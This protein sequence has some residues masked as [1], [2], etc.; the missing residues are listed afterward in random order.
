M[1]LGP[2]FE[3]LSATNEVIASGV[4]ASQGYG[5][6][7]GFLFA[8]HART[9]QFYIRNNGA[10]PVSVLGVSTSGIGGTAFL[11]SEMPATVE[12]GALAPFWVMFSPPTAEVYACTIEIANDST[13]IP[14]TLNFAGTGIEDRRDIEI[15][16]GNVHFNINAESPFVSYGNA[17]LGVDLILGALMEGGT[18]EIITGDTLGPGGAIVMGRDL[19]YDGIGNSGG[20]LMLDADGD[21]AINGAIKTTDS[22]ANV[23]NLNLLS[24]EGSVTQAA[25]IQVRDLMLAVGTGEVVLA[26][27]SNEFASV[28]GTA[29]GNIQIVD[30]VGAIILGAGGLV[31]SGNVEVVTAGAL[32]MSGALQ[33]GGD[34]FLDAQSGSIAGAGTVSANQLAALA[35]NGG[36]SLNIDVEEVAFVAG[37]DVAIINVGE[38]LVAGQTIANNGSIDVQTAAGNMAVGSVIGPIPQAG[39]IADGG[40]NVTLVAGGAGSDVAVDAAV[41]ST[42]G[43]IEITAANGVATT[44]KIGTD[45]RVDVLAQGGDISIGGAIDPSAVTLTA[46][47]DVDVDAAVAADDSI[48]V[49]AGTDGAGSVNVNAGGSLETLAAGSDIE[50]T[51]G[52]TAGN[53]NLAGDVTAVDAV[54]LA[55]DAVNGQISQTAGSLTANNLSFSAGESVSLGSLA[56]STVTGATVGGNIG[57]VNAG[58][59]EILG[60]DSGGGDIDVTS[61]LSL[62]VS[63]LV[64]SGNGDI[65]LAGT[66][67]ALDNA[68][69]AGL[70][71]VFLTANA[72]NIAGAGLVTADALSFSSGD[73]VSLG[74]LAVA[75]ATGASVGGN[76]ELVNAGA[77]AILGLDSGG[78]DI[79]V[80]S[81][82]SLTVGGMVSSGGG[83]ITLEGS[84]V[85]LNSAVNAGLG[86]VSLVA[87]TGGIAGAGLVTA[88]GLSFSSGD[89]VSLGSLAVSTVTGATVG[90]NIGMANAGAL[91]ILGL[92]SGGGDIDVASDL[93]LTVSGLV[94]SGNGDIA[95]AGTSLALDNAVNAGLGDVFLTANAGNIAGAGLVTADTLTADAATGID[96]NT[97]VATLDTSVSGTG[98][99]LIDEAYTIDLVEVDTADGSITVTAGEGITAGAVTANGE[100]SLSSGDSITIQRAGAPQNL[101]RVRVS[102]DVDLQSELTALPKA[103][104]PFT[105][106]LGDVSSGQANSNPV[107]ITMDRSKVAVATFF[108]TFHVAATGGSDLNDGLSWASAKQTIQSALDDALAGDTVLVSNGI[109]GAISVPSEVDVIGVDGAPTTIIGSLPTGVRGVYLASN[110]TLSGVTVTGAVVDVDGAGIYAESGTQIRRC[111]IRNNTTSQD[112]G[113]VYGG[114]LV[115]CLL[116]GNSAANGGGAANA[117]LNHCTVAGNLGSVSGGGTKDCVLFNSIVH[118]NVPGDWIG[119][120][121]TYSCALPLP[122]GAGNIDGDPAF[123]DMPNGNFRLAY[124]SPCLGVA[125]ASGVSTD[126]AGSP[127][128][129]PRVYGGELAYDMGCY[130][131]VPQARF[132]WTNGNATAPYE[133]WQNAAN[134]IQTAL[135]VSSGGDR[136]VVEAGTYAPFTVSNAV[137]MLGYRGASNTVVDG[138]GILRPITITAPA[139]LEGFTVQN[140]SAEDCGGILADNGAV[141]KDIRIA[142]SQATAPGGYG[143]GLCLYNG[144]IAEDVTVVSNRAQYGAGIYATATSEVH[145]ST[146]AWNVSGSG[147]GGGVYLEDAGTLADSLVEGNSG[148]RGGG[149]YADDSD[150]AT[151]TIRGNLAS[152]YGGGVAIFGGTLRNSWIEN[153]D[154]GQGAGIYA[155]DAFGH[156][157]IVAGNIASGQG[158]GVYLA[159]TGAV[160]NL[161]IVTNQAGTGGGGCW[162]NDAGRL[163]NSIAMFNS[164]SNLAPGSGDIQFSCIAPP[165]AGI[166][167]FEADP[168]FVATNDFHLRA[169]S[170][171]IDTGTNEAWMAQVQDIDGQQRVHP[172]SSELLFGPV[173]DEWVDIGADEA[174]VDSYSGPSK[175]NPYWGWNV[176]V[177]ARLQMQATTN[178]L[179]SGLWTNVGNVVTANQATL[180]VP[181]TNTG[182]ARLFRLIWDK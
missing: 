26:H 54:V 30:G 133:T 12:A 63:G 37:G 170:P 163:W 103:E 4:A 27:A 21:I 2:A 161:T 94:G 34:V 141:L 177:G 127:R 33:A 24:S 168:L 113:G 110:S 169:G 107:L 58:A 38:L 78:G 176:V 47:G 70:G 102:G 89:T 10:Q 131:Y 165:P 53:V 99:I 154:S 84:S 19:I 28:G 52:A 96:L 9:N 67:L 15:V 166:G 1:E 138:G 136:I 117:S 174:V 135:D 114:S 6:D 20:T 147:W 126:L 14:Y 76:I 25:E 101:G 134:D 31:S 5:T 119:G 125:V 98:D 87:T 48:A 172:P 7:Y 144:S 95:L 179:I 42:S 83:I 69:N 18:V 13:N 128:P 85:A 36:I 157:C 153:N 56:V 132:V 158:G 88:D 171:C 140:G 104:H 162:I 139:T 65:A 92:D 145:S 82:L 32:A 152:E 72:G 46:A 116:A 51:A 156:N 122:A 64:G 80:A 115:N 40:G 22:D 43:N 62:T 146:I 68:V 75:T 8:G 181:Y 109:Y 130:E 81:D 16:E 39:M 121:A 57:L 90:G 55:A 73:T 173:C 93:S 74:S 118:R 71:D 151:A 86:D 149:V 148:A 142:N 160:Y 164:P 175:G 61:D 66:S 3:V 35:V 23:L 129:Q 79:D 77:L 49:V 167:N 105:G 17:Q 159:G 45:G 50:L 106:W 97:E 182:S 180:L 178:L 120:S 29:H 91:A 123:V 11:C 41:A 124:E 108:T 150:I 111:I 59:L 143:G 112:G 137:V 60:L 100:I 155:S 44:A